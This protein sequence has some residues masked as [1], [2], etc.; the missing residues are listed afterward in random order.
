MTIISIKKN[1]CGM[2]KQGDNKAYLI[3]FDIKHFNKKKALVKREVFMASCPT[4]DIDG[5]IAGSFT[6]LSIGRLNWWCQKTGFKLEMQWP[7]I[8]HG[9]IGPKIKKCVSYL[10]DKG[11]DIKL[12]WSHEIEFS[13][14]GVTQTQTQY[15]ISLHV[16]YMG[17]CSLPCFT[18]EVTAVCPKRNNKIVDANPTIKAKPPSNES[19]TTKTSSNDLMPTNN[20]KDFERKSTRLLS[21]NTEAMLTSLISHNNENIFSF[22]KTSELS[23]RQ[24]SSIVKIIDVT[25][26]HSKLSRSTSVIK[27]MNNIYKN[28]LRF[29]LYNECDKMCYEKIIIISCPY[30][31][32]QNKTI[33]ITEFTSIKKVTNIP[34]SIFKTEWTTRPSAE[35]N[36]IS[37][38]KVVTGSVN[39]RPYSPANI[40]AQTSN[41][42]SSITPKGQVNENLRIENVTKISLLTE[43]PVIYVT[44]YIP[45]DTP[46]NSEALDTTEYIDQ[47][48]GSDYSNKV[49]IEYYGQFDKSI[50]K[51]ALNIKCPQNDV[52]MKNNYSAHDVNETLKF[53]TSCNSTYMGATLRFDHDFSSKILIGSGH[54]KCQKRGTGKKIMHLSYKKGE[55]EV[56]QEG[57]NMV[58]KLA[59][60]FAWRKQLKMFQ[61]YC[62]A[63][64]KKLSIHQISN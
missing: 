49:I 52:E 29:L 58:M 1:Q 60:D 40:T 33:K 32:K 10:P 56:F 16:Y 23:K 36:K 8:F 47:L 22:M 41:V 57:E 64:P 7:A 4:Q 13:E 30:V 9:S 12:K 26:A 2:K 31:F 54:G 43:T 44:Q 48:I 21:L 53:S 14:C 27:P 25:D 59:V 3:Y 11:I 55:C 35:V 6:D 37:P 24:M 45:Q 38:V 46:M 15:E 34:T 20:G 18:Q 50:A 5:K 19:R 28:E 51:Q 62:Y 17:V 63:F 39:V 42:K 61:V